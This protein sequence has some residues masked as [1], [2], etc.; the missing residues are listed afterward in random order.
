[1]QSEGQAAAVPAKVSFSSN[2]GSCSSW[3]PTSK[4]ALELGDLR[5]R[6]DNNVIIT[7]RNNKE[8]LLCAKQMRKTPFVVRF[9]LR[10]EE[11]H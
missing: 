10:E 6:N 7:T 1:M 3:V 8:N 4:F 2:A 5:V 9:S 11:N